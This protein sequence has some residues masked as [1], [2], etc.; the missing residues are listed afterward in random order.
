MDQV[1]NAVLVSLEIRGWS[2]N[3]RD[4]KVSREVAERHGLEDKR[5]ARVWK[6]LLPKNDAFDRVLRIGRQARAFHY[7]NTLPWK[8]K[9]PRIL[10]TA[11]YMAYTDEIRA[12]R[13]KLEAAVTHL[14]EEFEALKCQARQ[15][16]NSLYDESDYPSAQALAG[17]FALDLSIDPLPASAAMLKLG[18]DS[19]EAQRLK[20]EHEAEMAQTFRRANEDLWSRLYA[21]ISAFHAQVSDPQRSVREATFENLTKLLPILE[22]LNVT[23]DEKL[24]AMRLRLQRALQGLDRDSL[25][26]DAL[27]RA[28]TAREAEAV[29]ASMSAFMGA[30]APAELRHAA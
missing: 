2:G 12:C 23:G 8:H 3:K 14:G 7:D 16:L 19:A 30:S 6:S 18:I 13:T 1:S 15:Q 24:E 28:H 10:P 20:A 17:C 5:M 21:A 26:E 11:N 9:G 22:R 27:A 4:D 29:F 25:R